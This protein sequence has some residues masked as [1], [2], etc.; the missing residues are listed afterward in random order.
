LHRHDPLHVVRGRPRALHDGQL[1]ELRDQAERDWVL[2]LVAGYRSDGGRPW[3]EGVD[4][5]PAYAALLEALANGSVHESPVAE[6]CA[7]E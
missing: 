4:V 7:P 1:G 5:R 3:G 2:A 6:P